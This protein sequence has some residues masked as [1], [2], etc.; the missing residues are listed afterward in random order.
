MRISPEISIIIPAYN[1]ADVIEKTLQHLNS[2]KAAFNIEVIV[3][4]GGSNDSTVAIAKKHATVVKTVKSKAIQLNHAA[5]VAAGQILFFVHADM[6]ISAEALKA[7][8]KTVNEKGYDGGGFDNAFNVENRRIKLINA[9]VFLSF[10][11]KKTKRLEQEQPILYGD[12]GIFVKLSV[13]NEIGGFKPIPIMED[14]DLSRRLNKN[15]KMLKLYQPK[16]I[17]SSR[18]FLKHGIFLTTFSWLLIQKLY[19]AGISPN[20]LFKLYKDVR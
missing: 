19:K 5:A 17:V 10:L 8:F 20:I 4:D 12:N 9:L 15:H 7:I 18:R 6:M 13:F 2:F 11:E 16:L 14:Y 1:E 3:A